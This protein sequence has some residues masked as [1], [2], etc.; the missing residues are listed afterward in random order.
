MVRQKCL[1]ERT[2]CVA[3]G[4]IEF[5]ATNSKRFHSPFS[6]SCVIDFRIDTNTNVHA[7]NETRL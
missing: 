4:W 6:F 5:A 7:Y 2:Q 3:V 1:M